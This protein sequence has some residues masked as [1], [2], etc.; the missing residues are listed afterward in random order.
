MNKQ[1]YFLK[2]N[3]PRQTFMMDMSDDEK[4]IM[5]KHV[6][7]WTGLLNDGIA[8]VFGPVMA[9][10]GGYGAGVVSVNSEEQLKGLITNDPA[11]GLNKY[12]YYPMR[13]VFKQN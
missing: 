13:A 1:Q 11:N 2:L 6:A 10:N 3:P 7:Y 4:A 5:Q 9:P 12:E 8:I